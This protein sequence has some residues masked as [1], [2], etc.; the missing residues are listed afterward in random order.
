MNI[1]KD[2]E[3][4]LDLYVDGELTAEDMMKVR[5]HLDT[6]P[7]CQSYVDDA[8]TI[9]AA[10]PEAEETELPEGFH[11][12]VMT[13]ISQTAVPK[14]K[15]RAWMGL[16]PVAAACLA[17]A[18]A[19]QG[20]LPGMDAKQ[21]AATAQYAYSAPAASAPA[22]A[23]ALAEEDAEA[24]ASDGIMEYAADKAE[25][26]TAFTDEQ[27]KG[28]TAYFT[29]RTVTSQEAEDFLGDYAPITLSDGRTAYELTETEY[30]ELL[31]D[32]GEIQ[33]TA[34]S[35]PSP[36]QTTEAALPEGLALVIIQDE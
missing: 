28:R 30:A 25:P 18:V 8:L 34:T 35:A 7:A 10:F 2:Y 22:T 3:A 27:N 21:E 13:R 36:H 11:V 20:G 14:K 17:L 29:E 26:E 15:R 9:R 1:C 32:L 4:L 5:D 19:V 33:V 31:S 16:A 12:S 6:C 23:A 24:P